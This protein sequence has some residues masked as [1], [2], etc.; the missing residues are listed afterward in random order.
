MPNSNEKI[1]IKKVSPDSPVVVRR[2]TTFNN[3]PV[4]I[5]PLKGTIEGYPIVF[6][7]RTI[8]AGLF[9]EEIDPHALDDAALSDIKFFVNHN[10]SM[11]PLARHRRGKRSTMDVS[12]DSKG[13]PIFTQLDID[14]NATARELCSAVSR[15][16]IEDMSFAFGIEVSGEEWRDLDKPIPTRIITKISRV[17]EVS[18]VNDGAYPQTE[19]YARSASLDNAKNALAN[20]RAVALDNEKR[21]TNSLKLRKEKFLYLEALKNDC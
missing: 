9:Y 7:Q 16:D 1:E 8:I 6:S 13:M 2:S 21:A 5:E 19:I 15:G 10:D 17:F 3:Q 14:N 11:I 12:I 20:A 18:A 4:V